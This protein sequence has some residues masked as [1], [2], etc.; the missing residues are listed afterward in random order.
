MGE[1]RSRRGDVRRANGCSHVER[2]LI[3]GEDAA[4][5]QALEQGD[6]DEDHIR[7]TQTTRDGTCE[8]NEAGRKQDQEKRERDDTSDTRL[9]RLVVGTRRQADRVPVG[10]GRS[11]RAGRGWR[12]SQGPD[13]GLS[14]LFHRRR[15]R[16]WSARLRRIHGRLRG[17]GTAGRAGDP[18]D[19]DGRR[20]FR[21]GRGNRRRIAV[22][23]GRRHRR[24]LDREVR[25]TGPVR[26]MGK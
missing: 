2:P 13:Q 20:D 23:D 21:A 25:R 4:M 11:G 7:S 8:Q 22:R 5:R 3:L 9:G 1:A 17:A 10:G 18:A 24:V 6:G 19:D 26:R 15:R 12:A 16:L 14:G